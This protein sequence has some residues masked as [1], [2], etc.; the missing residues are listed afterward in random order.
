MPHN[1]NMLVE[2]DLEGRPIRSWHDPTGRVIM[3]NTNAVL[4]GNKI[5]LGSVYNDFIAVVDY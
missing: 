2:Y 4:Y 3:C 1:Y 5:Y